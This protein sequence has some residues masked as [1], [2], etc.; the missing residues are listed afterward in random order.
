M[1]QR[2]SRALDSVDPT[3]RATA[4]CWPAYADKLRAWHAHRADF[5]AALAGWADVRAGVA[6]RMAAPETVVEILRAVDAPMQFSQ[7]QPP[8]SDAQAKFAF[9]NAAFVRGRPMLADLLL[10]LNWDAEAVWSRVWATY[11]TLTAP[12]AGRPGAGS[13]R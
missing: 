13:D 5:T 4:E 10:F 11:N 3:G 1:R 2:L 12:A 9:I 7:L 6:E 8:V